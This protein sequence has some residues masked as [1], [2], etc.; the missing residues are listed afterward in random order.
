MQ[1]R[2]WEA[3]AA[4]SILSVGDR[5]RCGGDMPGG[6]I[7]SANRRI[8]LDSGTELALR[9]GDD[10][11]LTFDLARGRVHVE[12]SNL[13]QSLTI[14]TPV[15]RVIVEETPRAEFE[16]A[17]AGPE[18]IGF[19][20]RIDLLPSAYGAE[21]LQSELEVIVYE[22]LVQ[23]VNGSGGRAE[24]GPGE[25]IVVFGQGPMA[26]AASFDG[27]AR[28]PWWPLPE[29]RVARLY[30]ASPMTSAEPRLI[31]ESDLARDSEEI[32]EP[33]APRPPEAP[34]APR[35][36]GPPAPAELAARPDINSVLLA[37]TPVTRARRPVVEYNI[38]RRAP[39]DTE[40]TL[41]GQFPVLERTID[42]YVFQ[43]DASIGAEYEYAVA[44]A[45]RSDDGGLVEGS[46]SSIV[47]AAPADFL[48]HYLGNGQDNVASI[49]VDKFYD[50]S[51]RRQIFHVRE[52]NL[53]AAETGDI[54][55]P[56]ELV[57]PAAEGNRRVQIDFTTGYHL[58]SIAPSAESVGRPRKTYIISIENDL[59]IKREI[60]QEID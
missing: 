25:K 27:S 16:I 52:R 7:L 19:F 29:A 46:M 4:Y 43:D 38:Y 31:P 24:V 40:F 13:K 53:A 48:I 60:D 22:G 45:W 12:V 59:G 26:P 58:G 23:L 32:F 20:D 18:P 42:K 33:A 57:L 3:L 17:L 39:G 54:G 51:F 15:A 8:D 44:A 47:T 37:W 55:E 5:L 50:G 1:D 34:P 36:E 41:V 6:L 28:L 21:P 35:V 11:R 2:D 14:G 30:E 49:A 10:G 56:R 9:A